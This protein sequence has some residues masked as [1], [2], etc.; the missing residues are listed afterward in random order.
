MI[1]TGETG[2]TGVTEIGR[3]R[4]RENF[5]IELEFSRDPLVLSASSSG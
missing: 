4:D 5:N 3:V 1:E 2:E